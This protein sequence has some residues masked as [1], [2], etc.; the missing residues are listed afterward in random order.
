MADIIPGILRERVQARMTDGR[1]F[2]APPGTPLREFVNAAVG[3]A[4]PPIVAAIVNR[5]LRELT[6]PMSHDSDVT[7]LS[8]G[9]SD[10]ARI[11]RR[12]LEF[13]MLVAVEEVFPDAEVWVEHS[14][15]TAA[16]YY[17]KV[18]GRAPFTQ[19]DLTRIEARMQEIVAADAPIVRTITPCWSTLRWGALR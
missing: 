16:A 12:S 15:T 10:G 11:Y 8:S 4:H 1:I 9:T 2:E 18:R 14:A 13:L 3:T 7:C 5:R 6:F 19:A 17:C